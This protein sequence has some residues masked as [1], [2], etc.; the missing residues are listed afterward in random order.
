ME[1][2]VHKEGEKGR[3][4]ELIGMLSQFFVLLKDLQRFKKVSRLCW[5]GCAA[6]CIR[7]KEPEICSQPGSAPLTAFL[8]SPKAWRPGQHLHIQ[9]LKTRC[10]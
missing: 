7:L 8:S 4:G 9:E 5:G 6:E 1:L 3:N 10:H 2:N